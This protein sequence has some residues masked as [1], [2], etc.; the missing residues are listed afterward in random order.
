MARIAGVNIPENKQIGIGLSYIY[1]IGPAASKKILILAKID[2]SRK[3][4]ELN[5]EEISRLKDIIEKNYKIEGELRREI[6]M[7]IKRLKD[8]NCWRGVRHIKGL[9]VRGQRTKTNNRT[10]R[11]NVR[12]TMGS[13]RKPSSEKT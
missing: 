6:M 8:I 2:F 1:G 13:G 12:K 9:P 10:I 11:G 4:S 5:Q 7:N 3:A